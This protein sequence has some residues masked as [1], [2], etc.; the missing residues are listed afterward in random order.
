MCVL[1]RVT[2][3]MHTFHFL[4]FS[5]LK[6]N[7]FD[8]PSSDAFK[9]LIKLTR[10]RMHAQIPGSTTRTSSNATGHSTKLTTS[11]SPKFLRRSNNNDQQR[12]VFVRVAEPVFNTPTSSSSPSLTP[13]EQLQ[14][15]LAGLSGPKPRSTALVS[16]GDFQPQE[17]N[18][19]LTSFVYLPVG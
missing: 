5:N 10:M 3:R 16:F 1:L 18:F 4:S 8:H 15:F 6:P 13:P 11:S 7:G 19:S 14:K 9:L 17:T 2:I 12:Q